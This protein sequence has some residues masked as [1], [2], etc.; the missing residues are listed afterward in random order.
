MTTDTGLEDAVLERIRSAIGR[1]EASLHEPMLYGNEIEYTRQAI[2][3]GYV[4]SVGEFVDRFE[5]CL[6]SYIGVKHAI[7]VVNGTSGLQLSLRILG[8]ARGDEVICPAL[9]FAATAN[10]IVH[11]EALPLFVDVSE[12]DLG[13][14]FE[15]LDSFL[16]STAERT[17]SGLINKMTKRR[18]SGLI[19]MH[20][21]GHP[22]DMDRG[23]ALSEKWGVPVVEDAAEALGSRFGDHHVGTLGRLGV[24]SFNGNKI[25]TTGGG[26]A[27][28]TNDDTLAES[29]RKLSTTAKIPHAWEFR[30]SEVA[31]NFRMPNIN[32]ALGLA[33][34]EGLPEFIGAKR[35]LHDRYRDSFS[36]MSEIRVFSESPGRTSNH[37]LN[38]VI[39]GKNHSHRLD[40]LLRRT[41]DAGV[42][43]RP[44]WTPLHLMDHFS[45]MSRTDLSTTEDLARRILN[46]PS[47]AFLVSR[48]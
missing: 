15:K 17:E 16:E 40:D 20:T 8:V 48:R 10:A 1:K 21:F 19:V 38:A 46:V 2:E 25:V 39:L 33:Q 11:A 5:R 7:A 3:S 47:S 13:I 24:L 35:K 45:T 41:N 9:T 28:L 29:C 12:S 14:D 22:V 44:A 30:H 26:G 18:I 31:F 4:S 43:T 6:E 32:A 42:K 37:W 36:D 23:C 34:M 27:I